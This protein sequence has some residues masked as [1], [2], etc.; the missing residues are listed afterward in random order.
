MTLENLLH[1]WEM[2]DIYTP[3]LITNYVKNR[4]TLVYK[5]IKIWLKQRD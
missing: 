1:E 3:Y 5:K 4:A 2:T